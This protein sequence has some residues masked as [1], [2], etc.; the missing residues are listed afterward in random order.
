M[1]CTAAAK[2]LPLLKCTEED[3]KIY[4]GDSS[5]APTHVR[6]RN[7]ATGRLTQYAAEV[8]ADGYYFEP[9]GQVIE[10]HAY[11]VTMYNDGVQVSF[12][13]YVAGGYSLTPSTVSYMEAVTSFEYLQGV[14]TGD[15]FLTIA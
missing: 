1:I 9:D 2:C 6:L 3:A 4:V 11:E 15:Q 7:L 12:E 13:P 14:E 8:D 10:G 5:L